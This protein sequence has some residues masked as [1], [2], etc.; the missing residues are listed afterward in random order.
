MVNRR[1]DRRVTGRIEPYGVRPG[2]I[3]TPVT[4][5]AQARFDQLVADRFIPIYRFSAPED[6]GRAAATM[7]AGDHV[8]ASRGDRKGG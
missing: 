4:G 6:V 5:V 1:L 2:L 3:R 8:Q 7:A